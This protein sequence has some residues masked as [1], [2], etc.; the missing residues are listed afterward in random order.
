[1]NRNFPAHQAEEIAQLHS[2]RI[3]SN[4]R[5]SQTNSSSSETRIQDNVYKRPSILKDTNSKTTTPSDIRHF[6]FPD[7]LLDSM[8]EQKTRKLSKHA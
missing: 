1:M 2:N 7:E 6:N 4:I 8:E 5:H 3:L